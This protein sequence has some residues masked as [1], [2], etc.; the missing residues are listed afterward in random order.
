MRVSMQKFITSLK[1]NEDFTGTP[2]SK[3]GYQKH[4]LICIKLLKAM[5]NQVWASQWMKV[6]QSLWP[7]APVIDLSHCQNIFLANIRNLHCWKCWLKRLKFLMPQLQKS[8][9]AFCSTAVKPVISVEKIF[10]KNWEKWAREQFEGTDD[11]CTFPLLLPGGIIHMQLG[12]YQKER[13]ELKQAFQLLTNSREIMSLIY[14]GL[15]LTSSRLWS[16]E[17]DKSPEI[18]L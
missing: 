17:V 5:S 14:H 8:F 1:K 4:A 12:S 13:C 6:V 11:K 7:S 2:H 18:P 3:Q 10:S 16:P 15:F 9:R